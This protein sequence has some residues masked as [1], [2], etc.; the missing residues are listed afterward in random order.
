MAVIAPRSI[1][2][3][4]ISARIDAEYEMES[5]HE[6]ITCDKIASFVRSKSSNKLIQVIKVNQ[7]Y[8]ESTTPQRKKN[9]DW[10]EENKIID[11]S[12]L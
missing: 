9:K 8:F 4:V 2:T 7:V 11:L 12:M 10:H 5:D 1:N 6:D 3:S